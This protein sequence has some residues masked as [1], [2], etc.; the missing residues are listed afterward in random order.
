MT[1]RSRV[2]GWD[3]KQIFLLQFACERRIVQCRAHSALLTVLLCHPCWHRVL[4][5]PSR[6]R[7]GRTKASRPLRVLLL[8]L[9]LLLLLRW[10]SGRRRFWCCGRRKLRRCL[11][12]RLVQGG[13]VVIRP[14]LSVLVFLEEAHLGC[15]CRN[16]GWRCCS[17]RSRRLGGR[18]LLF[19]APSQARDNYRR[20]PSCI[21][22]PMDQC[23]HAAC[24]CAAV[25]SRFLFLSCSA[26]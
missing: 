19:T 8:L 25:S 20:V 17:R 22:K 23:T 18:L 16:R 6:P 10:R 24:S 9:L 1:V 14:P 7:A 2:D 12:L 26:F 21:A 3:T 5:P 15:R 4:P 11:P 13:I